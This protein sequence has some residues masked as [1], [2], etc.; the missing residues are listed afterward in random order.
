MQAGDSHYQDRVV[1]L[2]ELLP[3]SGP[4]V[5]DG[6]T[7]D[8]CHIQGPAVVTLHASGPGTAQ[9]TNCNFDG[10]PNGL[11]IQLAPEQDH[12]IGAIVLKDCRFDRCRFQG[13]GFLDRDR[14]FRTRILGG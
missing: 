2:H 12:L 5:I 9:I 4:P 6:F 11:F 14:E 8:G 13:V 1:R 3:D 7:F 10:D